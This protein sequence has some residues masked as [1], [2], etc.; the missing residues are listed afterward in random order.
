MMKTSD[1]KI[2]YSRFD[3]TILMNETAVKSCIGKR[4]HV[5]FI[6]VLYATW[7][8]QELMLKWKLL[9][10]FYRIKCKDGIIQ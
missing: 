9:K 10:H 4:N 6:W 7:Y 2:V 1:K 8:H 3:L 5:T